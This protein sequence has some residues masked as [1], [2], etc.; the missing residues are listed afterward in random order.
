M[1]YHTFNIASTNGKYR[2]SVDG[3][4]QL[5]LNSTSATFAGTLSA[6][7]YN[8]SNWNTAYGWGN[9]ASVGY[10]TGYSEVDTLAAVTSRGSSTTNDISVGDFLS[11]H[12][13]GDD[14][15]TKAEMLS[16]AVA[17]FR[18]HSTN[19]G[20][21]AIAQVDGGNSVGL[22]FT[23][24]AGSADWDMSLQPFGGN[25]GINK[26]NPAG[27][28]HVYSGT[29][30][31]F[32]VSG[33]VHVQG[34]TDLNINGTSRRLSFTNGNGT[35]RTTNATELYLQTNSTTA[36]TIDANQNVSVVGTLSASNY[37]NTNWGHRI[38]M[39]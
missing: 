39:G 5:S 3:T 12:Q 34:A 29:S 7:G 32:L 35:I 8:D 13:S 10:I 14:A 15:T 33:D 20:T 25:V 24:G 11:T 21:L 1:L 6:S 22:Q 19:S 26:I 28:L 23:N 27:A 4:E 31:R 16:Y 30:E 18:P 36:L 37:N 38:W 9:H 2:F 17:K